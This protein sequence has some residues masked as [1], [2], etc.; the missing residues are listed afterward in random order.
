M[1]MFQ[2]HVLV[3]VQLLKYKRIRRM[4]AFVV[5]ITMMLSHSD[6]YVCIYVLQYVQQLED[7]G[8]MINVQIR[9]W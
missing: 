1:I 2:R 5:I 6:D 9:N 7:K 3:I 4:C 8:G